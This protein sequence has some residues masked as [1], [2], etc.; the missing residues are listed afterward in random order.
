MRFFNTA[1]P[2]RSEDHYCVPPLSRLNLEEILTLIEQK[3]Y[4]VL[5]A[6]R[7]VGKTSYLLALMDY[8]NQMGTYRCLYVNVEIAQTAREDVQRGMRAI[9]SELST[10]ARD[11]LHDDFIEAIWLEVLEQRGGDAALGEVLTRWAQ[12]SDKPLILLLDE[13]DA[14][15]G[16]TLVAVLRQLR[17]GYMKRPRRFPQSIILCGVR[18][19]RDYRIHSSRTQAIITGGSACNVKAE[20]LRMEDLSS[21]E[22]ET[23]YQQHT[24]E[25]GQRFE[26]GVVDMA[27]ELTQ[28]QPWLVNALGYEVCFRMKPGRDRTRPITV[29]MLE[30]AKEFLIVRRETHL[31]QLADK[32]QEERV[33]TVIEPILVG[34]LP[35]G[36]LPENDVQ[37][38]ADLGLITTHGQLRIANPMYQ[39]VIPRALTYTTQLTISHDPEWYIRQDDRRLDINKLLAAFQQFFR[40]HAESWVERFDYKEAGPQLLLQ[41]FLQRIVNGGGRVEREYGL[42]RGRTDL[43][44]IWPYASSVQRVVIETKLRRGDLQTIIQQGIVQTWGYMDRCG[45]DEG[46]LIIF[47]RGKD[48]SWEEKIFH[49]DETYQGKR[50]QVWGM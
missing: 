23:L 30:E 15:V 42:G 17:A 24:T 19:V 22:V 27:W 20:S 10:M 47:D 8:L 18:D 5:H 49:R 6:P 40:E 12:R 11:Y 39:E 50:L 3:K 44:V 1:G 37:Y 14:L 41:A 35:P 25:T 2:V 36:H 28:G 32:L 21:H 9:L 45:A 7:Q 38:V 46:H 16:D 26:A 13:I 43:L 4:F 33:R 34:E 31:D 48:R 29:A